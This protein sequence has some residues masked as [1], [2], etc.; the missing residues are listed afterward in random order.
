MAFVSPG[1]HAGSINDRRHPHTS[2]RNGDASARLLAPHHGLHQSSDDG[3]DCAS[4]TAAD[5]L[6][7]DGPEIEAAGGGRACDRRNEGLQNLTSADAANGAGDGVAEI[8]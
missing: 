4:G 7:Y 6:T 5:D 8:A 1:L 2:I 3:Q